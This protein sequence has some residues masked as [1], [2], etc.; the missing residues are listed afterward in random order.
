[1][2]LINSGLTFP[3]GEKWDNTNPDTLVV[4]HLEAEGSNWTVEFVHNMH[5]REHGWNG[6]GYNYYIRTDG[7]IYTGRPPHMIGAHCQGHNTNTIGICFEGDFMKKTYLPDAQYQAF[8]ELKAYLE[9]QYGKKFTVKGHRE[10]SPSECPGKYFPLDKV[11]SCESIT[12]YEANKWYI[13]DGRWWYSV[14]TQGWYY[15]DQWA[16]IEGTWY[17]FDNTGF[18]KEKCWEKYNDEWCYLKYGG[19]AARNEWYIIDGEWYYF[20]DKC[21]MVKSKWTKSAT[22]E[23]WYYS[24]EDGKMKKSCWIEDKGKKYYLNEN[25]EMQA[26]CTIDGIKLGSDGATL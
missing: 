2:K 19:Y 13:K 20:D 4:H 14:N 6:I 1:M 25:G 5:I 12:E 15:K 7:V 3:N 18:V 10:L 23:I 16:Q 26:N 24:G 21:Y 11:K 17:C 8:C 9:N 22:R